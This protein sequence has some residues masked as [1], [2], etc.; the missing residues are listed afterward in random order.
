VKETLD[1]NRTQGRNHA[2]I[3][4]LIKSVKERRNLL[5]DI[6][7]SQGPISSHAFASI[8]ADLLVRMASGEPARQGISGKTSKQE[9][10][11]FKPPIARELAG[12]ALTEV[13][14]WQSRTG[15]YGGKWA[16]FVMSVGLESSNLWRQT[17]VFATP[18]LTC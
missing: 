1:G 4:P 6:A 8:L 5:N 12:S 15:E 14:T 18:T 16:F 9:I 10:A 3:E 11:N 2:S 17:A 13:Y 7:Y